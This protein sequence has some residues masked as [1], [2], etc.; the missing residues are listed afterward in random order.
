VSAQEQLVKEL[1]R[2][3]RGWGLQSHDLR[4]R[5]GPRLVRL[6]GI[7]K[8]DSSRRIHE[9]IRLWLQMASAELPPEL[10]RA[11]LVAFAL[12][13]THRHGKLTSRVESF[14]SEQ[15]WG[16]RTARRRIDHATQLVA[17]AAL[18]HGTA[19][20]S[21]GKD[22]QPPALAAVL[23]LDAVRPHTREPRVVVARVT[24]PRDRFDLLIR[25]EQCDAVGGPDAP[26][27]PVV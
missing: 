12:D 5:I 27:S 16:P 13:R 2:L 8:S 14:A 18:G 25:F 21:D 19:D 3:R 15:R 22:P 26:Q 6:C 17:Q 4:N 11:V 1:V 9:K 20:D 7:E 10:A 23:R 24:V